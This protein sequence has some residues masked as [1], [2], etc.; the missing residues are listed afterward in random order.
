MRVLL[1]IFLSFLF[2][3]CATAQSY[4]RISGVF[5]Q[6]AQKEVALKAF[7][8]QKDSVLSTSKQMLKEYLS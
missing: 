8:F 5:S 3:Y 1:V 4:Y 7:G 2:S 6:T